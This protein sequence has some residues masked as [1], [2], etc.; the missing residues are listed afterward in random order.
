ML[1]S[2]RTALH[3]LNGNRMTKWN[4]KALRPLKVLEWIRDVVKSLADVSSAYDPVL[5]PH[6]PHRDTLYY[7]NIHYLPSRIVLATFLARK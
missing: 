6:F 1:E 7:F 3:A 2:H 4:G 5:A